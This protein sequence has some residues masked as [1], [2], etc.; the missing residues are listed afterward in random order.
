MHGVT[1]GRKMGL[2]R[3]GLNDGGRVGSCAQERSGAIGGGCP[4]RSANDGGYRAIGADDSY[5]LGSWLC[6]RLGQP[7]ECDAARF[8][9]GTPGNRGGAPA[10]GP[11]V[12]STRSEP[13]V[14]DY[15]KLIV[16]QHASAVADRIRTV[17]A[18]LSAAEQRRFSDQA[19]RAADSISLN[20]ARRLWL[21][22][23]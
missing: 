5:R 11:S 20:I 3:P 14:G 1:A 21:E 18:R 4:R 22:R 12:Q 23:R 8:W 7:G 19:C 13:V 10:R 2:N 15:R 16:W 9:F 6:L 17:V